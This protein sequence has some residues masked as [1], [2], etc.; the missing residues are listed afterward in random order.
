M[1]N[2][3]ADYDYEKI[4]RYVRENLPNW[5]SDMNLTPTTDFHGMTL[6][7]RWIRVEE[8]LRNQRDLISTVLHQMDK[9]FEQVD[10]QLSIMRED[11][12]KRFEQVDKKLSIMR[13][14]MD[15]RFEQVDKQLS[16][17]RE[18]MNRRFDQVE[19]RFEQV[20]KRFE[21]V[22]KRF[23]QMDRHLHQMNQSLIRFMRWSFGVSIALAGV[24]IA[25][26][27]ILG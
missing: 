1:G 27:K 11:M 25:S 15:R 9:R 21:Q 14:D 20:D 4:G 3:A 5:L 18:D 6:H 7:E 26:I 22:D 24:V 17:M 2:A 13:E 19:K 16:I 10:K 12:D 23:E 8:E